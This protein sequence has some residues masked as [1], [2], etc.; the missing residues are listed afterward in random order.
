MAKN[1]AKIL[2]NRGYEKYVVAYDSDNSPAQL[3][4]RGGKLMAYVCDE[5]GEK[6]LENGKPRGG[7]FNLGGY[8]EIKGFID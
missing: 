6:L 7:L 3:K 1:S 8:W 4:A 5:R 2:Y